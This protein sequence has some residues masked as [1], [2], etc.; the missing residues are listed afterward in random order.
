MSANAPIPASAIELAPLAQELNHL[1]PQTQCMRCGFQG[2]APYAKAIAEANAPINQCPPGGARVI[3]EIAALLH[4]APIPLDPNRGI[5]APLLAARIVESD[6]IG[7]TKCIQAC[8]VDAIIGASKRMHSVITAECTG[9]ELC[10]PA[11]PVD[12]IRLEP[13]PAGRIT[14]SAAVIA[15]QRFEFRTARES[16]RKTMKAEAMER[17]RKALRGEL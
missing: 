12:C 5:E 11:C 13:H 7:C 14:P 3:D 9:C 1:L 4:Q 15:K 2:C 6:C 10:I 17:Q 16:H 8:P